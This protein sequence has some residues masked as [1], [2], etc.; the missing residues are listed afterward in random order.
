[1]GRFLVRGKIIDMKK[2]VTALSVLKKI[3]ITTPVVPYAIAVAAIAF[4][5]VSHVNQL[6][7]KSDVKQ[8]I[9]AE[10]KKAEDIEPVGFEVANVN[11]GR[12]FILGDGEVYYW[13]KASVRGLGE[14]ASQ[15]I[16]GGKIA[17]IDSELR[18]NGY[19]IATID[20]V[21]AAQLSFGLRYSGEN[22]ILIH[23]DGTVTWVNIYN[24]Q[25]K[26]TN[27][28][29]Y[30]DIVSAAPSINGD[31][32]PVITLISRNGKQNHMLLKD[33]NALQAK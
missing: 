27:L 30:H 1:M 9:A 22:L 21:N 20:V 31:G 25:A 13:P 24:G 8:P 14:Q 32:V 12:V 15:I 29:G 33:L 5:V 28:D 16:P 11:T 3:F 4:A 26:L 18:F 2:K 6:N 7:A 23:R 19:K 10:E 17:G